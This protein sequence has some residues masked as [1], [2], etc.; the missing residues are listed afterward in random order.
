MSL[1]GATGTVSLHPFAEPGACLL[2]FTDGEASGQADS[3]G[4]FEAPAQA[5]TT[6]Q[7]ERAEQ[8]EQTEQTEPDRPGAVTGQDRAP[9]RR[10]Q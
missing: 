1:G 2:R 6:G 7:T 4:R 9:A 5:G 3:T 10:P 8:T